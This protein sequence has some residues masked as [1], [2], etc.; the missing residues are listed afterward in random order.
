MRS[1]TMRSP[2]TRPLG[3]AR[4]ARAAALLAAAGAVAA[5]T[6]AVPGPA[7]AAAGRIETRLPAHGP[8]T[9]VA[10]SQVTIDAPLPASAGPHP[11]AC[12]T[13]SYLRYRHVR[14]PAA[15]AQAARVLVAQPGGTAGAASLDQIARHT[16]Q[17]AAAA[18]RYVELWAIDRRSN[19]LE[20]NTGHVAAVAAGDPKVALDYYTAGAT[21]GGRRFAG[22]VPNA[23]AA[24]L[25]RL[26]IAQTVADQHTLLTREL[27]DP[28]VRRQKVWCGGH[29]LGGVV[30]AFFSMTDFDGNPA[31]LDDAGYNQCAGYFALDTRIATTISGELPQPAEI[32][33][34]TA[35]GRA[36]VDAAYQLGVLPYAFD[37]PA[38][39][40]ETE[41]LLALAGTYA[42]LRPDAV[43]PLSNA[44]RDNANVSFATAV[45]LSKDY[46]TFATGVPSVRD[47]RITNEAALGALMDDNSM[48]LPVLQESVGFF[49]GGRV[50]EKTFPAPHDLVAL[51]GLAGNPLLAVQR[52]AAPDD[53]GPLWALGTGPVYTWQNYDE[54]GKPGDPVY[55]AS[56]GQ[57]F[58]TA[59]KEVTDIGDLA[60][61]L[62]GYPL[63]FTEDY[64]PT[65]LMT[66]T[67]LWA[68]GDRSVAPAAIHTDGPS[69]RPVVNLWGGDGL[70]APRFVAA[71]R[72][73]PPNTTI[74]PGYQHLDVLTAASRQN[75]GR[76][77]QGA[78]ALARF[79]LSH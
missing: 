59:A 67:G 54:I 30:T 16:V 25:R 4:L 24:W 7:A 33:E 29:S 46:E 74:L 28:A 55:R 73:F 18:G 27:P 66:D 68:D 76:P 52:L 12:D 15:A 22:Y 47:F 9:D 10:V 69:R 53:P 14:G 64:F 36:F 58:T 43:S 78:A 13:L 40:P 37:L 51:L 11:A 48:P 65:A 75:D 77:E 49:K 57:P 20:D 32:P 5:L 6:A 34:L 42:Q 45:L 1:L 79:V 62:A 35:L 44:F 21:V 3:R 8:I 61:G 23:Q 41:N 2:A 60:R 70:V 17:N 63:D 26:G 39:N 19:C 56:D 38:V 31:T 71:G 50:A 72:P